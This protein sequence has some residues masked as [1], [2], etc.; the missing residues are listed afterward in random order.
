MALFASEKWAGAL[1]DGINAN[2]EMAKAGK[3]FDATI[4]SLSR[5]R[6][7]AETCRSGRTLR[8]EMQH[9]CQAPMRHQCTS[10][11]GLKG[12]EATVG[13]EPTTYCLGVHLKHDFKN[14]STKEKVAIIRM[15]KRYS[16]LFLV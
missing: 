6:A 7:S 12:L 11:F 14:R 8:T 15:F 16:D 9:R 10:F 13:L 1:K 4:S 2:R 3:G 5:A